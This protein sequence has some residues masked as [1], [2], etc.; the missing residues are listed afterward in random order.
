MQLVGYHLIFHIL[1]L[2]MQINIKLEQVIQINFSRNFKKNFSL[3]TNYRTVRKS[4]DQGGGS[5]GSS[6][7]T[8]RRSKK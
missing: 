2:L 7:I 5:E 6:I 4:R 1:Y 8:G 3:E